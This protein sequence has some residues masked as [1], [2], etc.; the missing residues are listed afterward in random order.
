VL[1]DVTNLQFFKLILDPSTYLTNFDFPPPIL[2]HDDVKL[3]RRMWPNCVAVKYIVYYS[4]ELINLF[5]VVWI[6][7]H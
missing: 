5:S 6:T 3:H 2:H 1:T 4:A 7:K